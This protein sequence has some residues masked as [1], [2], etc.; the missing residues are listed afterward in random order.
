MSAGQGDG[1]HGRVALVTGGGRGIGAAAG[2]TLARQGA[3]VGVVDLDLEPAE[4]VATTIRATGGRAVALACDVTQRE[5]VETTVQRVVDTFGRLD[6]LVACAGIIRDN[7]LFKMSDDDWQ[8]VLA[9]HLTGSFLM[10]RAVQRHLVAQRYGK[11]VFLSSTSALGNRGQANYAA[12][13]AGL[14]GFVRTLAIELGPFNVNVNAVAPGFVETRMTRATAERLGIPYET[15][16][17]QR[18]A[19]I[20]LRRVGQPQDVANVIAF[21]VDDASSYVSGQ[22]IYVAGGPRG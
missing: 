13:K 7:L 20:P 19:E 15:Y 10:A 16:K 1:L 6:I 21:L 22:V 4:A 18:A 5:Q 9:T 12:A 8:A 3:A 17:A 2:E 11:L 14:Q